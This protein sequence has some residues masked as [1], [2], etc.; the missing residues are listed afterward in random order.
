MTR[1]QTLGLWLLLLLVPVGISYSATINSSGAGGLISETD[2]LATVTA[3]DNTTT[4][5]DESNP[6]EIFGTGGQV[7]NGWRIGQHSGGSPFIDC[8]I[9]GVQ[10]ACDYYRQLS[11][12]KKYGVKDSSAVVK[13]EVTESTGNVTAMTVDGETSG[14]TITLT[15]ERH[16]PVATCQNATASA[17]FDLATA[18]T[19]APTCD[20]GSNTQKGYLAFDAAT[21]ESFED[22]W[23]LPTGFT[24]AIDASFRWKA[25]ATSGAVGWCMQL[26]RVA[27]GS[28]SDPAYPAQAS[29]NCVSDTAKGTTLQENTATI[30]GVTCSSCVAGD[31]VYV[32]ISRDANGGAVTDDMSGDALLLTYG[33]TIRIAR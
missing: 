17:N 1:L 3:R 6:F 4:G 19:P 15:D 12:G 18:N 2:T 25:A 7:A 20:T 21:D 28:T 29:G 11:A 23:I 31:H 27:D 30:T 14:V 10:N 5:N 22:S 32:R 9:S 24:G 16:F 8:L 33:R 26:I 13:F